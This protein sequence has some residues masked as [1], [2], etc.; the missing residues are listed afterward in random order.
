MSHRF[1]SAL[2]AGLATGYVAGILLAPEKGS[3]T[4]DTINKKSTNL[5][6][7]LGNKFPSVGR[8]LPKAINPVTIAS[9]N[10]D[11]WVN[12]A[13]MQADNLPHRSRIA[14]RSAE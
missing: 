13:R 11:Y 7:R 14:Y 12:E 5:L 10:Q 6:A 8:L 2:L 9:E 1:T 3:E 4:I